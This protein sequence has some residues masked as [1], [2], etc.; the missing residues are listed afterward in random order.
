[1][2]SPSFYSQQEVNK[3]QSLILG[4][5]YNLEINNPM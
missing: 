4:S 5:V 2:I 1:M 3:K